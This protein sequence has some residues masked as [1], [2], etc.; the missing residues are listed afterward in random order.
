MQLKIKLD[1]SALVNLSVFF[2][3]FQDDPYD[4]LI[5]SKPLVTGKTLFCVKISQNSSTLM[6][7]NSWIIKLLTFT[8]VVEFLEFKRSFCKLKKKIPYER[9]FF[10]LMGHGPISHNS[11]LS[12]HIGHFTSKPLISESKW[13]QNQSRRKPQH[14]AGTCSTLPYS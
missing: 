2:P 13:P 1:Q 14:W 10:R 9:N 6:K 8:E 3:L 5:S 7:S 11:Y 4:F 12:K